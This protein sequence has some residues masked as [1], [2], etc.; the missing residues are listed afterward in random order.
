MASPA[1][2]MSGRASTMKG[3]AGIGASRASQAAAAMLGMA[4]PVA[5]GAA[6]GHGQIGV[7]ASLGGLA[8]S[9][10][11]EGD[12]FRAQWP[13]LAYG[14]AATG[15]AMLAGSLLASRGLAAAL[16]VPLIAGAAGLF[17]GLSRPLARASVQF[18]LFTV[19]AVH[20]GVREVHP[21][22]KTFVFLTGAVWTAFLSLALRPLFQAVMPSPANPPAAAVRPRY[23]MKQLIARWRRSLAQFSG[24]QYTLRIALC[25]AAAETLVLVW[26]YG[27]GYWVAITAAIVVHRNL[28]AALP[29]ALERAGGTVGGVLLCGAL[30]FAAPSVW[31][32]I[33]TIA[34]LAALRP[35]LREMNYTVYAAVMTPLVIL[36][37]DYGRTPSLATVMDRL[38]ATL[39]GCT[40]ALT[41]G[42]LVWFRFLPGGRGRLTVSDTRRR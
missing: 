24:W 28:Q 11:G 37:L 22:A 34:L 35:L 10:D 18:I 36:L 42:Y 41:L 30:M 8:V 25:L 14:L 7:L 15:L 13:G 4:V 3:F 40:L 31:G 21:A 19:I 26:P 20:L 23:T 32:L 17:G 9:G 5:V 16:A 1:P 29:R 12:T 38:V 6:T 2:S 33:A 39:A 27:H